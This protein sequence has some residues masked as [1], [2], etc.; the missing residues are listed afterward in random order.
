MNSPF[1]LSGKTILVTG[2]SSGIGYG[3][4]IACA[5]QGARII[6]TGRNE[7]HL[8]QL[9]SELEGEGHESV[10]ADLTDPSARAH[11]LKSTT[12][13][14]GVVHSAGVNKRSPI[15]FLTKENLD[16]V[17]RINLEAPLLLSAQ[18]LKENKIAKN[19]SIVF[20]DSIAG[21]TG[22]LGY[23]AYSASKGGLLSAARAMAIELAPQN[24]RVNCIAPGVV[25][26]PM[27]EA[28]VDDDSEGL[29]EAM[30]A[31]HPL[32]LGDPEDIA[33]SAVYLLSSAARWVTGSHLTIDGGRTI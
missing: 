18:L 1:S 32:G 8:K 31:S 11:L 13:L 5:R 12:S 3:T 19:A 6:A 21:S 4:A 28:H 30:E 2:A 15:K 24:I 9:L 16:F 26:T 10:A 27:V 25:R 23:G 29:L 7:N 14:D 33:Y 22:F 20:I 17:L